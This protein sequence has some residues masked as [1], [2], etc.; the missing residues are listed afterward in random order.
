MRDLTIGI[1]KRISNGAQSSVR[2]VEPSLNRR[3]LLARGTTLLAAA[4]VAG[5]P[6]LSFGQNSSASALPFLDVAAAGSIRSLLEGPVQQA[7]A[8]R[9]GLQLRCHT[10]GADAVAQSLV[11]GSLRAD[12]FLPIT[13]SPMQTLLRAGKAERAQPVARTEFVLMYSPKSRFADRF[14]A[15]A[16]GKA[17][18]WQ[19]L[20]GPGLHLGR[21]NPATDPSG[22]CIIFTLML[23]AKKYGQPGLVS[24]ILGPT[25]NPEQIL[26]GG[27]VQGRLASGDLDALGS[28]KIGAI[29]ANLPYIALSDDV[30]LSRDDV[31]TEHPD[32]SLTIGANVFYPEPLIFYAAKLRNA[33]N[34]RGAAAFVA[35]LQ[36]EEARQLFH[37]HGFAS[38][39]GARELHA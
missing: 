11:D 15:A 38:P 29:R 25:L 9:L 22:R 3:K 36:G 19:V 32:V 31:R 21:S 27:D 35:W 23:A 2:S 30:N 8:E 6:K 17:V 14:A 7:V 37:A 12:V 28:Y 13:A 33:P 5:F 24:R 34:A 10:G 20:E 4:C 16:A 18:W 1:P 26:S 39:Q